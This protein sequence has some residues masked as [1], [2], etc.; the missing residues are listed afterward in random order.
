M[1]A[2]TEAFEETLSQSLERLS[3][4]A[5]ARIPRNL[6]DSIRYSLLSPGKR[7]RPRLLLASARLCDVPGPGADAAAVALEMVHCFTLI[8]DDLPCMDD[9]DT[10][11]GMPTN[12]KVHGEAIA[13]LAGDGL[14]AL[15]VDAMLE[16]RTRA[17]AIPADRVIA[18]ITRLT[19]AMG[20][21]GVIGGQAAEALLNPKSS[22]DATEAMHA[23]KT[24]ALFEAAV[25]LPADLAGIDLASPRGRALQSFATA[26]GLGFQAA[27]DLEDIHEAEGGAFPPTSILAHLTPPRAAERATQRLTQAATALQQAWG[28]S[29]R[30]LLGFGE[31]VCK[32]AAA[33]AR[34]SA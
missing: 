22:I 20:P 25:L 4:R 19:Q 13:L 33:A 29:A 28:A 9:D 10:R 3:A 7:I 34:P 26:L 1:T 16:I 15:A 11:R 21:R 30:E 31:E 23:L 14:M 17:P 2:E 6:Y 8:H 12:H 18:A 5:S 27:D 32:K 24:G